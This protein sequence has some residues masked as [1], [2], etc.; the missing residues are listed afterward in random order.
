MEIFAHVIKYSLEVARVM[1]ELQGVIS[2]DQ[3]NRVLIFLSK[4]IKRFLIGNIPEAK[5]IHNFIKG[6]PLVSSSRFY[7]FN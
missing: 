6:Y 4:D 5:I 2:V 3:Q 1:S 7:H